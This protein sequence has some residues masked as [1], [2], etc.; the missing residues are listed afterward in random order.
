MNELPVGYKDYLEGKSEDFV[1]TVAPILK[2]SAADKLH[3]VRIVKNP[4]VL[5]A[6]LDSSIPYGTV[7]EDID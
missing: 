4:H 6:H 7:V 2:Q 3:G 5:Q 1:D